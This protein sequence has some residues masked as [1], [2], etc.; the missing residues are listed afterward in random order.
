MIAG[1]ASSITSMLLPGESRP[2]V[3]SRKRDSIRA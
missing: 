3:V 1:I 2:K